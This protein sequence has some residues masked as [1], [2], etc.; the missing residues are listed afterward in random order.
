[1]AFL[2]ENTLKINFQLQELDKVMP[3]GTN[4]HWFGLTDG[5]LW[6]NVGEQTIYEYNE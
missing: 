4:M 1:M 5:L 6:I 3:W 2:N